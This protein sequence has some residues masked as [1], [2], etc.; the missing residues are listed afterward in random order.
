MGKY[1]TLKE[2]SKTNTGIP[3]ELKGDDI[4][5]ANWFIDN[6]LDRI[7]FEYGKPIHVNSG[8]RNSEVNTRVG[9]VKNSD[10]LSIGKVFACDITTGNKVDNKK[11]FDIILKMIKLGKINVK[12]LID[13]KDFSWIHI[14]SY[15]LDESYKNKN[16][17]LKL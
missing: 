10:H 8:Y 9:G 17:I 12:Q 1:F 4:R 14:S 15:T 2:L 11:L 5:D 16:Q 6:I 3:N 7:R 13:E